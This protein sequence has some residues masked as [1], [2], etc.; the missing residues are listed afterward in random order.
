MLQRQFFT[1]SHDDCE[2]EL[3][4]DEELSSIRRKSLLFEESILDFLDFA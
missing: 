2:E 4:Y 3:S 1:Q